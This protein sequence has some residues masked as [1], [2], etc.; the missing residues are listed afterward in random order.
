LSVGRLKCANDLAR[1]LEW[2]E[3][4]TTE[5]EVF[6]ERLPEIIERHQH[7]D[8]VVLAP[9]ALSDEVSIST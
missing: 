5:C 7:G 1:G 3:I 4:V 8:E 6:S 2:Y 9:C